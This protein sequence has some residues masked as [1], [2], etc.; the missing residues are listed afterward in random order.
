MDNE[1]FRDCINFV[2]EVSHDLRQPLVT[3]RGLTEMLAQPEIRKVVAAAR[4][5]VQRTGRSTLQFID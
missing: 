1:E 2:G 4:Q 5:E 3:I